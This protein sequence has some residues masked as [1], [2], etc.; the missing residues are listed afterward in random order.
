MHKVSGVIHVACRPDCFRMLLDYALIC[1]V[2]PHPAQ[3]SAEAAASAATATFVRRRGRGRPPKVLAGSGSCR[4][5]STATATSR[6][7][8]GSRRAAA[9]VQLRPS[10]CRRVADAF[11]Q[12]HAAANDTD[13]TSFGRHIFTLRGPAITTAVQRTMITTI[14]VSR[15]PSDF[16]KTGKWYINVSAS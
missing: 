2:L 9:P 14:G 7:R 15:K 3:A 8:T 5:S 13:D 4:G 16:R 6:M 12:L 1:G 10:P 11:T